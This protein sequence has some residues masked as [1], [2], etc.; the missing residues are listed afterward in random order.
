[1]ICVYWSNTPTWVQRRAA[2]TWKLCLSRGRHRGRWTGVPSV[3]V[4]SPHHQLGGSFLPQHNRMCDPGETDRGR[5]LIV[6]L[7]CRPRESSRSESDKIS[8]VP[9][10]AASSTPVD[11]F[12]QLGHSPHWSPWLRLRGIIATSAVSTRRSCWRGQGKMA[13]T[14]WETASRCLEP[15]HSACCEYMR[16]SNK[17]QTYICGAKI[18]SPRALGLWLCLKRC[19]KHLPWQ[20]A[21]SFTTVSFPSV[22]MG[23]MRVKQS[24][25]GLDLFNIIRAQFVRFFKYQEIRG[26]AKPFQPILWN[27]FWP[28]GL[29]TI[30]KVVIAVENPIWWS[31]HWPHVHPC[32]LR[33]MWPQPQA[34]PPSLKPCPGL[35][36]FSTRPSFLP[37]PLKEGGSS[38]DRTRPTAPQPEPDTFLKVELLV[39]LP[40]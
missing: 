11:Y 19:R 5:G 15:M 13:A 33:H 16:V 8:I 29:E 7:W 38:S 17:T 26:S 32:H 18:W 2:K 31:I 20:V 34:Q 10:M 39:V 25:L 9:A 24:R 14:W 28:L 27:G 1:M 21:P 22:K 30:H 12:P 35:P 36:V 6:A 40:L 37:G 23:D 3:T 4:D